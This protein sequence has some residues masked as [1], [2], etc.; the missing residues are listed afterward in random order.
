MKKNTPPYDIAQISHVLQSWPLERRRE[1]LVKFKMAEYRKN[2]L[3]MQ[4]HGGP[5]A[6]LISAAVHG[7]RA[8]SPCVCR[9]LEKELGINCAELLTPKELDK[10]KRL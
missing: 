1:W 10:Y 9:C 3:D 2:F 5:T 6:W 8:W 7:Q 4:R